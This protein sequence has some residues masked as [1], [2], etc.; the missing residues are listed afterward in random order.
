MSKVVSL[1]LKDDQF[2]AQQR[3]ARSLGRKPSEA[4][5]LLLEEALRATRV[6]LHRVPRLGLWT[7][8]IPQGTRLAVWHVAAVAHD[9][10]D[11]VAQIAGHF[12][13][14]VVQAKALLNYA[15]AYPE[16]IQAAID[17]DD[18]ITEEDLDASSPTRRSFGYDSP[19]DRDAHPRRPD[20]TP[21]TTRRRRAWAQD[22]QG[23]GFER[24]MTTPS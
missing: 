7:P 16:E 13:I 9:L 15:A 24:R 10:D 5:A 18:S 23:G 14:S 8:G 22:W 17:D 20:A 6:R 19:P 4:A 1:R 12:G 3:A 11:D 21:P 2:K